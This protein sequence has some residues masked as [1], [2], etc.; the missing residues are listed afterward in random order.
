ME[1]GILISVSLITA[2]GGA[3]IVF[4]I[5][6]RMASKSRVSTNAPPERSYV[7]SKSVPTKTVSATPRCIRK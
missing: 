1:I 7:P 2:I 5:I 6:R 3:G 4:D